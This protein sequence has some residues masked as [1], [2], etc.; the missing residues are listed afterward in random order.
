[1][2]R[3]WNLISLIPLV[4]AACCTVRAQDPRLTLSSESTVPGGSATLTLSLTTP[5][6]VA[7][8]QWTLTYSPAHITTLSVTAGPAALLAGKSVRCAGSA[9]VYR[10]L[11][12]GMNAVPVSGGVIAQV[13]VTVGALTGFAPIRVSGALGVTPG[14]EAVAISVDEPPIFRKQQPVKRPHIRSS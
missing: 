7:G 12:T 4:A 8:L 1:M 3:R 10:C 9:G 13:N 11:L 2:W 6:A 5:A 14:A